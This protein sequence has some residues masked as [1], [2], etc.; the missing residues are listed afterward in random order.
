[1][2]VYYINGLI[3]HRHGLSAWEGTVDTQTNNYVTGDPAFAVDRRGLI[4]LWNEAA[5]KTLGHPGSKALG[6][7]CWKLLSGEDTYGNRYCCRHCPIRDMAFRNEPVNSFQSTYKTASNQSR[8]FNVSCVTVFDK[9][10]NEILLHICRPEDASIE[11]GKSNG[12]ARTPAS[13]HPGTL[14]QREIEVLAL[15][16][17]KTSTQNIATTMSISIRTVRTH[18]QHL[19]Y[20]LQVHKRREAVQVGKRLKLI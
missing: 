6:Q 7:K 19:M 20:K 3:A 12:A 15:L 2:D 10:G 8:Q 11:R 13:N 17:D 14:S 1:L 5:E 18:I 16:A 9:P 4:V